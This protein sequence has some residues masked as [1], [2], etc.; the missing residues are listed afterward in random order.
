MA[1][2][3]AQEGGL[4]TG[5]ARQLAAE[6]QSVRRT[7][8]WRFG[9]GAGLAALGTVGKR[10]AGKGGMRACVG[11]K[12]VLSS[13]K[14]VAI[15]SEVS[16]VMT[17][18]CEGTWPH[19]AWRPS[20]KGAAW[21]IACHGWQQRGRG[22]AVRRRRWPPL[23][24]LAPQTQW[25]AAASAAAAARTRPCAAARRLG[26]GRVAAHG[27]GGWQAAAAAAA[28]PP[29]WMAAAG[30]QGATAS[31]ARAPGRRAG[32]PPAAR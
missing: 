32:G 4:E 7:K 12:G 3:V 9:N 30:L 2:A 31:R 18:V 10:Q 11:G 21:S 24:Q 1:K 26:R 25:A 27:G 16:V 14:R 13:S 19:A 29:W 5:T 23:R 28:A 20:T 17:S 6:A 8:A 15:Q 22:T